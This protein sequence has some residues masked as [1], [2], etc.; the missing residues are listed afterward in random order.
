MF[1]PQRCQVHYLG[2][3]LVPKSHIMVLLGKD[4]I[5][6]FCALF[7]PFMRPEHHSS[8]VPLKVL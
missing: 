6:Q 5:L 2:G 4:K 8:N 7:L 3:T 1:P